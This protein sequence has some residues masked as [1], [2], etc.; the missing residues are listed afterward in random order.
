MVEINLIFVLGITLIFVFWQS[1]EKIKK[2]N[3][4]K[5]NRKSKEYKGNKL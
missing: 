4:D 2:E 5:A 1:K 3:H